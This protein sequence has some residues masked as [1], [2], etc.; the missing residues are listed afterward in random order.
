[1]DCPCDT[2]HYECIIQGP[3][4]LGTHSETHLG[5]AVGQV[6][7]KICWHVWKGEMVL[8]VRRKS[9]LNVRWFSVQVTIQGP[10]FEMSAGVSLETFLSSPQADWGVR[11]E[12]TQP[13]PSEQCLRRKSIFLLCC[14]KF[15]LSGLAPAMR[16]SR[17]LASQLLHFPP[18]TFL[19]GW[20]SGRRWSKNFGRFRKA[21]GFKA[22]QLQTLQPF[23]K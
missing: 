15:T 18:S 2:L 10:W 6:V 3:K 7:F 8:L 21:P 9:S 11:G 4:S 23:G 22:D 17:M 5:E 13:S 19:M 1:M 14:G 20:E 16:T 12:Y